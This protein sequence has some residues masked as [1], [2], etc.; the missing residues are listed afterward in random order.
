[1]SNS[2]KVSREARLRWVPI[3]KMKIPPTAQRDQINWARVNKIAANLNVERIGTPTVN[4]RDGLFWVLDGMHRVEALKQHG[5]GDQQIQCWTYLD[6]TDAEMADVFLDLNDT[7]QVTAMDKFTKAVYA[8]R[9]VECDIDRIVRAQGCHIGPSRSE[10]TIQAVGTVQ[11]VYARGGGAVLGRTIRINSRAFGDAGLEAKLL[12]GLGLVCQ[13][14]NGELNED[15]MVD[16]LA[17]VRG[18]A[19]GVLNLA[20]V[21]RKQTGASWDHC[22]ADAAVQTYNRGLRG[23]GRLPDW[24]KDDQ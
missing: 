11:K 8:G 10:G 17:T 21:T 12:A 23:K 19:N 7:L 14:F 6:L 16:Q 13:R 1:M 4:E 5:W 9:E 24:W 3:P 20:G 18:G 15:R 22:V 2:N